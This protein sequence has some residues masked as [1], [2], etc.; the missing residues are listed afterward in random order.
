MPLEKLL[1]EYFQRP[2]LQ[3][4]CK[5]I[6]EP[7]SYNN[8]ELIAIILNE[9]E[10]KGRN[11]YELFEYLDRPTLS[12][13]CKAYKIDHKGN[14]EVLLKRIKKKKLLD[15]SHT[16]I[17]IGGI[18]GGSIV[19]GIIFFLLSPFYTDLIGQFNQS[20]IEQIELQNWYCCPTK[21]VHRETINDENISNENWI[22]WGT[23]ITF[24]D[25]QAEVPN[26]TNV[27]KDK[28]SVAQI[29][30]SIDSSYTVEMIPDSDCKFKFVDENIS[31]YMVKNKSFVNMTLLQTR[32]NLGEIK[33]EEDVLNHEIGHFNITQIHALKLIHESQKLKQNIYSCSKQSEYAR[34]DLIN[35]VSSIIGPLVLKIENE[36]TI[37]NGQYESETHYGNDPIIQAN[38]TKKITETLLS[39]GS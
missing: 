31:A 12:R 14:W 29:T 32:I 20:E 13:I 34:S 39:L 4:A 3:Q 33:S 35:D 38:W 30:Q 18:G 27:T 11:K 36:R 16:K 23:P 2:E 37:M 22:Y 5:D 10:N 19:L 17:K 6:D 7:T 21:E 8:L 28:L 9:W 26:L 15:N 25:F 24:D 1:S